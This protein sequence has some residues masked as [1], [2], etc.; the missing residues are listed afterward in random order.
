VVILTEVDSPRYR[1]EAEAVGCSG[2]LL[3][4][5]DPESLVMGVLES[6]RPLTVH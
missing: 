3:K 6:L 5:S 4:S 2:Y 1:A